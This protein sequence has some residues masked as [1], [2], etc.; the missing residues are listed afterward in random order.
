MTQHKRLPPIS[1]YCMNNFQLTLA[2]ILAAALC[3]TLATAQDAGPADRN[4]VNT[5]A[6]PGT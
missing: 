2:I 1:K 6:P 3:A 5:A 4:A